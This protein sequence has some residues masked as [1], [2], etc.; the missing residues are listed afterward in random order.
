MK[1]SARNV[2]KGTVKSINRG[3][4]S[5]EIVIS[6]AKGLEITSVITDSA[7]KELGLKNG[8]EVYAVIKASNVM[9]AI[10]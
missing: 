8:A 9:I 1:I 6:V 4:V 5:A 7:T 3:P 10:E 2:I